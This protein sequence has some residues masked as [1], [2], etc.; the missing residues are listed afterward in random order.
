M[1]ERLAQGMPLSVAAAET[2]EATFQM[3]IAL[4]FIPCTERVIEGRHALVKMALPGKKKKR[5]PVSVSLGC[6][7]LLELAR[8]M[9]RDPQMFALLAFNFERVRNSKLQARVFG[10]MRHPLVEALVAENHHRNKYEPVVVQVI[11]H[12]DDKQQY[13]D[14]KAVNQ[15]LKARAR[16]DLRDESRQHKPA[17]VH[18]RA[19]TRAEVMRVLM[20]QHFFMMGRR[21]IRFSIGVDNRAGSSAQIRLAG[22][23]SFIS[24]PVGQRP[25]N[26]LQLH[27]SQHVSGWGHMQI[28]GQVAAAAASAAAGD[29]EAT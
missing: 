28:S 21:G 3:F 26:Q 22:L 10:L 8:R 29:R 12:C 15:A 11:Y 16:A 19:Q 18:A 1:I 4:K 13:L 5:S 27:H 7:R 24:C 9:H 20:P 14:C 6:G 25:L 17:E 2:D 23:Q